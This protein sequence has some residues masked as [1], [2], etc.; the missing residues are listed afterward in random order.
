MSVETIFRI[1]L[2]LG[3]VAWLM[4]FGVYIWPKLKSMEHIEAQRAIATLH[5]F[6]FFGLVFIVP[7]VVSPDLPHSFATVA[8]YGDFATGVL[9]L[10]ALALIRT[11]PLFWALVVAYN[12][13]GVG[14]LLIDYYD[15][16]M[17]GLPAVAG[18]FGAMYWVPI[19][20]VPILMITHIASLYLLLRAQRAA[21][22]PAAGAAAA[23]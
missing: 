2:V 11:R 5:S 7:G 21:Q 12:L 19:I 6:R 9:A 1:H 17:A 4:C 13:V 3:Y 10:L 22:A 23:I 20:Y 16:T 14:D 8:A 15:A 18:E